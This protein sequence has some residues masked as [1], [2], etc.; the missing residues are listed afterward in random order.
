[1]REPLIRHRG[2]PSQPETVDTD[3]SLP[4]LLIDIGSYLDIVQCCT[5]SRTSTNKEMFLVY[6]WHKIRERFVLLQALLLENTL[7]CH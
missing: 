6:K 5:L 7:L 2:I 3:S 4:G 1:M